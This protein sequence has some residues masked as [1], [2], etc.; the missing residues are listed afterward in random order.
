MKKIIIISFLTFIFSED[1]LSKTVFQ[2]SFD[3]NKKPFY[4]YS[5]YGLNK[6]DSIFQ[7]PFNNRLDKQCLGKKSGELSKEIL[8]VL[9]EMIF[10]KG[11][12]I[13]IKEYERRLEKDKKLQRCLAPIK[14][15]SNVVGTGIRFAKLLNRL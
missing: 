10:Y 4:M 11:E 2:I 12:Y 15:W 1:I 7:M 9:D 8:S 5:Y 6:L 13:T 14:I 3:E